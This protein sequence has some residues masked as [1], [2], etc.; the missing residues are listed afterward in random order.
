L[1]RWLW[2]V[3]RRPWRGRTGTATLPDGRVSLG[4]LW[5]SFQGT[6]G[7]AARWRFGLAASL[8]LHRS[9]VT[10]GRSNAGA[11]LGSPLRQPCSCFGRSWRVG[12]CS[13]GSRL[14]QF[15]SFRNA[16][17]VSL[18][19]LCCAAWRTWRG[20]LGWGGVRWT[21]RDDFCRHATTLVELCSG[22]SDRL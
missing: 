4:T 5:I 13:F 7:R 19:S 22:R 9:G 17:T 15:A 14:A 1:D 18:G 11:R 20:C 12:G 8:H 6:R 2:A 3:V 10:D 21:R 16:S